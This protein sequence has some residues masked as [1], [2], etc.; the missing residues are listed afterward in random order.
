MGTVLWIWNR[1][2]AAVVGLARLPVVCVCVWSLA[3]EQALLFGQAK[4]ASRERAIWASEASLAR[5]RAFSRDPFYSPK[6]E[7]LLTGYVKL[8]THYNISH[9]TKH[10]YNEF[11]EHSSRGNQWF[12]YEPAEQFRSLESFAS[13]WLDKENSVNIPRSIS[14]LCDIIYTWTK[15]TYIDTACFE[16][17]SKPSRERGLCLI[18]YA[19]CNQCHKKHP[20]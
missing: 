15:S 20:F 14:Q 19:Y 6:Q 13:A 12:R 7:S 10:S 1:G 11:L 18:F 16:T 17:T 4:R 9:D 5:T 8:A 2:Q 3:C